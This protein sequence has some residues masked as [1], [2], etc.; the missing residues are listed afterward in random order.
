MIKIEVNNK[1]KLINLTT[2]NKKLVRDYLTISNPVF[3]KKL[4]MGLAC[5]GT[6]SQLKY[7]EDLEDAMYVPVGALNEILTIFKNNRQQI[8]KKN[9]VDL[10]FSHKTDSIFSTLKFKGKLR[11]YQEDIVNACIG[12]TCGV[13]EA[14]TGSG[15]TVVFVKMI[16]DNKQNTLVLV[17]TMELANQT[18]EAIAKFTNLRK[19]DIGFIGD[20]KFDV[21]PISVGLHQTMAKLKDERWDSINDTFGQ[22]IADEVHIVAAETYMETMVQLKAKYKWGFSATPRRAD[23]LTKVIFWATGPKLHTVPNSA[24]ADVLVT[25]DVRIIPTKYTFPLFSTQEYGMMINDL[26]E[27]TDRNQLILDTI[28]EDY[29]KGYICI[30]CLRLS[31]VDYLQ[32]KLKGSVKLT[33][34]MK[35]KDRKAVMKKLREKETRIVISTYGLFSTGLDIPHLDTLILAAPIRSEVKIRQSAGRLMRKSDGKKGAIIVDFVDKKVD[36]LKY[37]Y[38]ARRKIYKTL[39]DLDD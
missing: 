13:I 23:G 25:P 1:A 5:W 30:L 15:K 17:N 27:D 6:P 3:N 10:R 24:L 12:K 2:A 35:K 22:I 14:M 39:G 26:S 18:I 9:I 33:S 4:D 28:E 38:Y 7:F 31:Q 37:Q 36:L 34:K 11:N 29:E 8:S 19:K 20:G 21:K 16:V 32:T